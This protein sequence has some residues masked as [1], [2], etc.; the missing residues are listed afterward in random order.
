MVRGYVETEGEE[1]RIRAV[2]IPVRR[3]Y[4][5]RD[6]IN[7]LRILG[8][9]KK[10]DR[11]EILAAA[12]ALE[13]RY[14]PI[15]D[16]LASASILN[17]TRVQHGEMFEAWIDS[18]VFHDVAAKRRRYVAMLD[19]LGKAVEGIALHL[20]ELMAACILE[21]DDIAADVLGERRGKASGGGG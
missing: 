19:E 10:T 9:V 3:T 6:P 12:A 5:Q 14:R 13:A 15:L 2:C 8:I 11:P 17:D 1:A 21:L 7:F 4:L 20:A 18:V 16:E